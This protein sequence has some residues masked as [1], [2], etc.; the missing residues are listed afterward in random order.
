MMVLSTGAS[1]FSTLVSKSLA[2]SG[3]SQKTNDKSAD[4]REQHYQYDKLSLD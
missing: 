4:E 1:P 3:L 2:L